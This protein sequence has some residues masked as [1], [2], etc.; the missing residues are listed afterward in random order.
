MLRWPTGNP[1]FLFFFCEFKIIT[2]KKKNSRVIRK[3]IH[4]KV[5]RKKFSNIVLKGNRETLLT[6]PR[7]LN[8]GHK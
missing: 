3:K 6:L 2:K 1:S 4:E 8:L 7:I 5:E